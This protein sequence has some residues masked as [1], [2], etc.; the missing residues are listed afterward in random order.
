MKKITTLLTML[1]LF[2]FVAASGVLAMSHEATADKGK[3]LFNDP[4]LGT[5]GRSCS[6]CHKNGAGLERAAE[7]KDIENM[8]NGCIRANLN[9]RPLKPSSV[10]MQSL[11][12]YIL[13]LGAVKKPQGK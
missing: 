7:R 13:S 1:F 2:L 11:V 6:D 5:N 4:K 9:G 10:E 3:A 12:L 8:I